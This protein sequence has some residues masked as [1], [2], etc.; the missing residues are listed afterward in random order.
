MQTPYIWTKNVQYCHN[1]RM[2]QLSYVRLECL[3]LQHV[4]AEFNN[5]L[6]LNYANNWVPSGASVWILLFASEF[7]SL[8]FLDWQQIQSNVHTKFMEIC[9]CNLWTGQILEQKTKGCCLWHWLVLLVK[10]DKP[11]CDP[12]GS[13]VWNIANYTPP[14]WECWRPLQLH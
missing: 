2:P 11:L 8:L 5:R 14:K 4:Q 10:Y 7:I 6:S 1:W 9:I 13:P 3:A 12:Q